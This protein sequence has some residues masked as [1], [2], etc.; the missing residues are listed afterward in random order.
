MINAWRLM[1]SRLPNPRIS[2][3]NGINST[4]ANIPLAFFNLSFYE[5][6]IPTLADLASVLAQAKADAADC[7]HHWMH[8]LSDDNA[9]AGWQDDLA[10]HGFA[11]VMP[12]TGME[13][14][15]LLPPTRSLPSLDW[16]LV[17]NTQG[18]TDIAHLNAYAYGMPTELFDPLC[19]MHL[20]QPDSLA[21]V[22]YLDGQPA[23]SAAAFPVDGTIYIALVATHLDHRSKGYAEAAIRELTA[24]AAFHMQLPR[25][26]LHASAAG[27]P[28]YERM[29]FRNTGA[30][31]LLAPS[32]D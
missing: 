1:V 14:D 25:L 23:T 17:T 16:Q 4:F 29:G 3:A 18:A 31:T 10:N 30:F 20:W 9:P 26:T 21:L 12:L 13:C 6:P 19:N 24:A 15:T 22:G 27:L 32:A 5:N 7:P 11:A 2:S 8:M 28:V